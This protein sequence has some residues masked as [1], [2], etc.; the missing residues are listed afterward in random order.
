[1]N[2]IGLHFGEAIF[3]SFG[4]GINIEA[5]AKI[6]NGVVLVGE[7]RYIVIGQII[8]EECLRDIIEGSFDVARADGVRAVVEILLSND[9]AEIIGSDSNE[10]EVGMAR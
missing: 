4:N 5:R 9:K 8:G 6:H 1:M 10:K 3:G 2:L 7:D